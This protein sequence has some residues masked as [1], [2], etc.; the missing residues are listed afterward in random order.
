MKSHIWQELLY[1]KF[2]QVTAYIARICLKAS[3]LFSSEVWLMCNLLR[4]NHIH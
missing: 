4:S 3:E 1:E 2:V